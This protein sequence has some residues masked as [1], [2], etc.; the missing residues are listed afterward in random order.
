[1]VFGANH[2]AAAALAEVAVFQALRTW[3]ADL[4]EVREIKVTSAPGIGRLDI[5]IAYREIE[6]GRHD[7]INVEVV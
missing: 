2:P 6:T 3:M 4:I 5:E 7:L 1:M